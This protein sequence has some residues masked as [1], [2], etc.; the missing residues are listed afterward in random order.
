MSTATPVPRRSDRYPAWLL[1]PSC[2]YMIGGHDDITGFIR[3][4]PCG[5][6]SGSEALAG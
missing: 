2:M 6:T 4:A 3:R 5:S 1:V